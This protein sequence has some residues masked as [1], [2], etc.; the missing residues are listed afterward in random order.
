MLCLSWVLDKL[1]NLFSSLSFIP[2]RLNKILV[3]NSL[4]VTMI[5]SSLKKSG[6][7]SNRNVMIINTNIYLII[8]NSNFLS[9]IKII[10]ICLPI[11]R[12]LHQRYSW[13]DYFLIS[14]WIWHVHLFSYICSPSCRLSAIIRFAFFVVRQNNQIK[15]HR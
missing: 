7:S 3:S 11:Q 8:N 1:R 14:L 6:I 5:Y 2:C 10:Q 15:L 9:V 4:K 13:P 12:S